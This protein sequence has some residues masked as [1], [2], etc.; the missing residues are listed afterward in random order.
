MADESHLEKLRGGVNAWNSWRKEHPEVRPDLSEAKLSNYCLSNA[1]LSSADLSHAN[2]SNAN[3]Y[4]ADLSHANLYSADLSHAN[5]PLANIYKADLSHATLS[6]AFLSHTILSSANLSSANLSSADLSHANL[7]HANIYK[8]DLSH[9]TLSNATVS[10]ANLSDATL[11]RANL[12]AANLSNADL[13]GA[14]FR[15]ADLRQASLVETTIKD[16][17]FTGCAVYGISVW[18]LQGEPKDQSNLNIISDIYYKR[19]PAI[20]VDNLEVAQF[21]Y[22]LLHHEKL[23]DVINTITSKAVLILG[24]FGERKKY[25][26][27]IAQELRTYR[28]TDVVN[29]KEL[30]QQYLPIIFDFEKPDQQTFTETVRT[31]AH[32]SR[33]I[34]VDLT[35]PKSVPQELQALEHIQ[36]PITLAL[37][38]ARPEKLEEQKPEKKTLP[39]Y[40]VAE[41]EQEK[42]PWVMVNDAATYP[43]VVKEVFCYTDVGNLRNN[44]AGYIIA[45]AEKKLKELLDTKAVGLKK[46][47][48]ENTG[49]L[50]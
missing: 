20:T 1:N 26:K 14:D 6:Y 42:W 40:S 2:L 27:A 49:E 3:L 44:V 38:E 22:L 30:G 48:S 4:S 23:R 32:L 10:N 41:E 34:V 33:F 35:D 16:A 8:A 19:E 17:I 37:E 11:A 25:L 24:R 7:S 39:V 43:G 28:K 29:D 12:F 13:T 46:V 18:N 31:L 47:W 9:A 36:V 45:P 21:V 15:D 5:L 50:S